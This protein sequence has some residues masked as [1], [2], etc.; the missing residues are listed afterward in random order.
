SPFGELAYKHTVQNWKRYAELA[1]TSNRV[2]LLPKAAG[3]FTD[4]AWASRLVEDQRREAG[5]DG[6]VAAAREAEAI[7][8]RAAVR[9]RNAASMP[10]TFAGMRSSRVS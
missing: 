1:G 6:D 3:G 5:P 9:A 7:R 8:L 4:E 10:A 2:S